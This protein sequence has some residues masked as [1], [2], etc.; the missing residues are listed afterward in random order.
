MSR[1]CVCSDRIGAASPTAAG[2]ALGRAFA[3]SR[4]GCDQVAV[5]P[6]AAGGA[7]LAD[8]LAALGRPCRVVTGDDPAALGR[9]V[10]AALNEAPAR[11]VVDLVA[12]ADASLPALSAFSA[13][14]GV[15]LDAQPV[16]LADVDLIVVVAPQEAS[17]LAVGVG[18]LAARRGFERG[19]AV[20]DVLREDAE[21]ERV[22]RALGVADEPGLGAAGGIP[23]LLRALGARITTGFEE[24]RAAA[25]LDGTLASADLIVVGVDAV[26]T[27]NFGGPIMLG[28]VGLAAEL[29][30]PC[31]AVARTVEISARELRRHGVESA[32]ALGGTQEAEPAELTTACASVA[33][34]WLR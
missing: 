31:A 6:M 24:C 27:G 19:T 13:G 25:R 28:I 15:T 3:Q 21:V 33:R 20:A 11:L 18:G 29:A 1:V 12:L 5:V 16:A 32:H 17:A 22:L 7:D 26:H 2:A 4:P 10:A 34:A 8:A 9:E 23:A 30:V 14:L